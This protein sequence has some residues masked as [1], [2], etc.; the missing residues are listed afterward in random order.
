MVI[1]KQTKKNN[2]DTKIWTQFVTKTEFPFKKVF[3][4]N[5][6]SDV[7][8]FLFWCLDIVLF[9]ICLVM[10]KNSGEGTL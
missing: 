9:K 4:F 6:F 3:F 5:N 1:W 2:L 8:Y 10:C 7:L